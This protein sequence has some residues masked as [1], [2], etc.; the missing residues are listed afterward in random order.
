MAKT[1]A[2]L[3][4]EVKELKEKLDAAG[5]AT[6]APLEDNEGNELTD[7]GLYQ[8]TELLGLVEVKGGMSAD[9]KALTITE[10]GVIHEIDTA[11][12]SEALEM[13]AADKQ[14]LTIERDEARNQVAALKRQIA[15]QTALHGSIDNLDSVVG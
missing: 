9:S 1:N 13:A 6:D 7:E 15:D 3:T 4:A 12:N 2:Q 14:R 10:D 5:T 8:F 11:D